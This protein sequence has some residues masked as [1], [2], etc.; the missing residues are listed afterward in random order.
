MPPPPTASRDIIVIGASAGAVPALQRLVGGLPA[1]FPASI[2]IVV[3]LWPHAESFLPEILRR[4]GP[5]PAQHGVHGEAVVPGRIYVAPTDRHLLV[6]DGKVFISHGPR[7]NRFRPAIN[8]LFRSAAV[9]HRHRVIGVI[10]TGLLD[11]GAAGLWAV[12]ECGGVAIVQSDPQFDEMPRQAALNVAV[13]HLVPLAEIPPLLVRLCGE[14]ALVSSEESVPEVIRLNDE[15]TKMKT[16][17]FELE[18]VGQ[19]SLFTCPECNGALWEVREGNQPLFS[20]HVGH[21]YTARGLDDAQGITI[22]QS[23]W[24]AVR[25]LKENAAMHERLA[26]RAREQGLGDAV[27]IYLKTAAARQAEATKL[28]ELIAARPAAGLSNDKSAAM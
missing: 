27:N 6:E 17:S 16:T 9:A 20:C 4:A 11:D 10:L 2:F 3:H 26:V 25:A 24:S 7:E 12:K 23:L 18:R 21:S 28:Q 5:L 8:P 19:R 22:E 14:P 13:D 15:K 1:D